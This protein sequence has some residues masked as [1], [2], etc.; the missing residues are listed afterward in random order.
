MTFA[1]ASKYFIGV[2]AGAAMTAIYFQLFFTQSNDSTATIPRN[3]QL[4]PDAQ[5]KE[6]LTEKGNAIE[7]E[8]PKRNT[9]RFEDSILYLYDGTYGFYPGDG[10]IAAIVNGFQF[11]DNGDFKSASVV[12]PSGAVL[13]AVREHYTLGSYTGKIRVE[14]PDGKVEDLDKVF[15]VIYKDGRPIKYCYPSLD[16]QHERFAGKPITG[17]VVFD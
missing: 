16:K 9:L 11:D 8:T 6:L 5:P 17:M 2:L 13:I 15:F 14:R 4:A 12:V 10:E 7:D 3:N 1:D